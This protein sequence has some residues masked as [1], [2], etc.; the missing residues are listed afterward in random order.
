MQA[1]AAAAA[2]ATSTFAPKLASM[3]AASSV[4]ILDCRRLP[5]GAI[6]QNFV[7]DVDIRD[8]PWSALRRVVLRADSPSNVGASRTREQEYALLVAAFEAEIIVPRPLGLHCAD[9]AWPAFMLMTYVDGEASGPRL[10]RAVVAPRRELLAAIGA[11]LANVHRMRATESLRALL[12]EAP[13]LPTRDLIASYRDSIAQWQAQT[14]DSRP[15]LLWTLRWLAARLP[16]AETAVLV[17][18][19]YRVGN[20]LVDGER[21]TATLDWEF[22]GWGNPCEDLGWFCAPCWR[23]ARRDLEAGGLGDI[24][25]LLRGYNQQ[26]GTAHAAGELHFWQVLGQLRWAVI[27]LQ[28]ALRFVHA[29]ERSLELALTGRMLPELEWQLL[30]MTGD[31]F[32]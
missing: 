1:D 28:Q 12:G 15:V 30:H 13:P 7:L 21:L 6:Q 26:A 2:W 4:R 29:K 24:A 31:T 22:A 18:R 27:A 5:G 19:D 25:D 23:F 14:G 16:S 32:G 11:N 9:A 20:L 10:T 3:L 8:G 17:H